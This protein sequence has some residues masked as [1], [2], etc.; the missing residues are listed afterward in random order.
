MQLLRPGILTA[1]LLLASPVLSAG[2]GGA[3]ALP[4]PATGQ[5]APAAGS[6]C[7]N[8]GGVGAG[9]GTC[10]AGTDATPHPGADEEFRQATQSEDAWKAYVRKKFAEQKTEPPD[11]DPFAFSVY[12]GTRPEPMGTQTLINGA[13]MEVSSLIVNDPLAVVEKAYYEA[14]VRAGF[15]PIAGDVVKADGVR[16]VSYRPYGSRNLKTVTLVPNGRGTIILASVGNPEELI[17]KKPQLPADVPVPPNAEMPSTI[18]QVEGNMATRSAFLFV[19]DTSPEQ[20]REFYRRELPR[21]GFRP[22]DSGEADNYE[23]GGLLLSISPSPAPEPGSSAVSI[24][25]FEQ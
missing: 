23:K 10:A 20:V 12:Q 8:P 7:A 4:L 11:P 25:W 22:T 16:F 3:P 13:K 24:L 15:V 5:A 21:L 19:R 14:F 2:K 1:A 9:T 17:E 18:Q 6:C